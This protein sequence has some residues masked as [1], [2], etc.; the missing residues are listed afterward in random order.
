MSLSSNGF[1]DLPEDA[2]FFGEEWVYLNDIN[3]YGY[4]CGCVEGHFF[5]G[6]AVSVEAMKPLPL[7]RCELDPALSQ[8]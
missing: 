6:F 8:Q 3:G 7:A 4:G 2:F 5:D 1:M